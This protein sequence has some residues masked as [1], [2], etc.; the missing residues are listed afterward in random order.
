M[1]SHNDLD[2]KTFEEQFA[3]CKLDPS[4][5][6]HEAHLRL[7]WVHIKNYGIKQAEE[8]IQKQL[9][10]YVHHLG[11]YDKYNIT[12]TVAAVMIVYHFMKKSA[13]KKFSE[14]VEEFPRLKYQFDELIASHYKIDIFKSEIAK[15]RFIEPDLLSFD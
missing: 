13:S 2:D 9:K 4:V 10:Q 5:F 7:A 8:N 14:F 12:L 6:N 1:L 3:N 15:E 11:A